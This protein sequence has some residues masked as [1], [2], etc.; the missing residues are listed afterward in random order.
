MQRWSLNDILLSLKY[1]K[2]WVLLKTPKSWIVVDQTVF[3]AKKLRTEKDYSNLQEHGFHSYY[4]AT[5][6]KAREGFEK[7]TFLRKP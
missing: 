5:L 2:K 7:A 3:E 4:Q 6:S 1:I